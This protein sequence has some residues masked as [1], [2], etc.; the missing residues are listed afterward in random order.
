MTSGPIV[1]EFGLGGG[2]AGVNFPRKGAGRGHLQRQEKE[3]LMP[4]HTTAG[5][6]RGSRRAGTVLAGVVASGAVAVAAGLG[7]APT[8]NAT[9]ASFFGIGNSASCTSNLIEHR[10]RHRHR[11]HRDTPTGCSAAPFRSA[12][13]A[14][15]LSTGATRSSLRDGTRRAA[16]RHRTWRHLRSSPLQLGQDSA[17]Y[18]RAPCPLIYGNFGINIGTCGH[19][20][21]SNQRGGR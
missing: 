21:G 8:A 2:L 10:H 14:T 19:A 7:S 17:A 9:C 4:Q 6:G 12:N 3:K 11:R 5:V 1:G 20:P 13:N 16:R 15:V 18:V